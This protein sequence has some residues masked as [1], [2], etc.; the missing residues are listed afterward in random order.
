MGLWQRL[1]GGTKPVEHY[2]TSL[3]SPVRALD[4]GVLVGSMQDLEELMR[5]GGFGTGSMSKTGQLV[6]PETSLRVPA[7]MAAVRIIAGGTANLPLHVMRR[8]PDGSREEARESRLWRLLNRRPCK[9][10]KSRTFRRYAT[11]CV[12]LRGNFYARMVRSNV[13]GHL[14][15]LVPLNPERVR[16]E[17]KENMDVIYK[18]TRP[19]DGK[20][21]EYQQNEIFHLFLHTLNGYSG[22]TPITYA[23]ETIGGALAMEDHTATVYRNGARVSGVFTTDKR[24]GI[25]GRENIE[26][27]LAEYRQSGARDGRD[28]ILED[29]LHYEK[30]SLTPQDMQWIEQKKLNATDIFMIFGIPPHMAAMVEK[31]TSW[32]SGIEE[33]NKGFV[34]WTLEDYLTMW[35]DAVNVDLI[36]D[37]SDLYAVHVR[38]ALVRGNL[39]DR[40]TFYTSALQ[41]GWMSPNEV[42]KL[43]DMNPRDGGEQFYPPPNMNA[44]PGK[45]EGDGDE[46]DQRPT[47]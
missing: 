36:P 3:K 46:P 13:N 32:G 45:A 30:M 2:E 14:L 9:F 27:S 5:N 38:N 37:E 42:R 20:E 18:Y 19:L 11:T 4:G 44:D 47:S 17:Q 6:S 23:R 7:V 35:E 12:L 31:S 8:L 40:T 1:F 21:V 28:L 25:E 26:A 15:E 29:G 22:V 33:Q 41:F 34:T 39:K 43:E 24:L 16:V 10:M